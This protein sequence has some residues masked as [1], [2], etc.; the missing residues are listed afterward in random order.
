MTARRASCRCGQLTAAI[1]GEPVRVSVCHCNACKL[2]TG[3]PFGAQARFP[4]DAVTF[5]GE[6]KIWE[7]TADSGAKAWHRWCPECGAT[8]GYCNEG[9]EDVVAIALGAIVEGPIPTPGF[10]VYENRK[11]PWVEIV[12]EDIHRD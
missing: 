7:R 9:A 2:R 10:S 12:G 8:I 4:I 11:L 3:G 6:W 1:E 5:A